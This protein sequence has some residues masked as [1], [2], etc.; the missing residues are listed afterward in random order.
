MSYFPLQYKLELMGPDDV[1]SQLGLSGILSVVTRCEGR[2]EVVALLASRVMVSCH[3]A[4][5]P[6]G[7]AA[8]RQPGFA[9]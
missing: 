3:K 2:S 5:V 1:C 7:T 6:P 9:V 4:A 8:L